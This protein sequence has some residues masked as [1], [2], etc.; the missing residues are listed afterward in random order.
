MVEQ[1]RCPWELANGGGGHE[2]KYNVLVDVGR[3]QIIGGARRQKNRLRLAA[4][5]SD[6]FD[7]GQISSGQALGSATLSGNRTVR[8]T[9][10]DKQ[11]PGY[12][13]L[14]P[15]AV[16]VGPMRLQMR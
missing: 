6:L 10:E 15:T 9:E 7:V 12:F 16:L 2:E 3:A 1:P 5:A 11:S 4:Q 14:G 8:P 13:D